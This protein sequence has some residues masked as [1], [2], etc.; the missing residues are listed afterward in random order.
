[1]KLSD[2]TLP[3]I[4]SLVTDGTHDSP[5]LQENG[6]PFIKG[7]HISKGYIDF[8]NCDFITY[9]DH[10]KARKRSKVD[11]GDILFANIG[12]VGSTA[13]V[14]T[15]LE[16]SIKNVALFKPDNSKV[17]NKYLYYLVSSPNFQSHLLNKRAGVAQPFL[18]LEL[19]RSHKFSYHKNREDQEKIAKILSAYDD[20]ILNNS[21]RINIIEEIAQRIYRE[22]FVQF[23]FP[24]HQNVKMVESELG[25]I[26]E[27]WEIVSFTDIADVLSG[28]TP[29]TKIPE[30][31]N[32]DIPFFAPKDAPSSCY[33]FETEKS[34]TDLGLSKCNSQ[35]Y[36]KD[37]VFITARGT[38]GKIVMPFADMA[39]NQSCYALRGKNGVK[40]I[41]LFLATKNGVEYLKKNTGGATFDTIIVDTFKR[42]RIIKPPISLIDE[43][44]NYVSPIFSLTYSLISTNMNLKKTRDIL[45]P[46]LISDKIDVS[47]LDIDIGA[48]DV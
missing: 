20:L 31:W 33:V 38:V 13:F 36:P 2:T 12:T 29:K 11:K 39:M 47:D 48:T 37:T 26:P 40:Q 21:I 15:D 17:S 14:N 24:G 5:K 4:C 34:I 44:V 23:R 28:G 43:F 6:I 19:L 7:K 1:M 25:M 30:Y 16:F 8:D 42:M 3:N 10:L 27:G 32:G 41:Y 45:L 18:S 46:K 9:E 35:L 22:W